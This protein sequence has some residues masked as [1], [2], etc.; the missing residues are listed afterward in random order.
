[1]LRPRIDRT[2]C[3]GKS[4]GALSVA[5]EAPKAMWG[6]WIVLSRGRPRNIKPD[7]EC[8]IF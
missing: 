7:S 2:G 8:V 6:P 5:L 4:P 3:I 1:L